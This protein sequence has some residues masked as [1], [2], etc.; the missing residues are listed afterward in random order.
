MFYSVFC[1]AV[2]KK[3]RTT[4]TVS[5]DDLPPPRRR[6]VVLTPDVLEAVSEQ[7][8]ASE[9]EKLDRGSSENI[10]KDD[11]SSNFF[12][13][14]G[15]FEMARNKLIRLVKNEKIDIMTPK[16]LYDLREDL[17]EKV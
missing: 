6:T 5:D 11:Q 15:F 17:E 2:E 10:P 9:N 13:T 14:N 4:V 16:T 8:E 1:K 7:L 12:V 3:R